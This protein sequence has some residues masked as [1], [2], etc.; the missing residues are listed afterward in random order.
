MKRIIG[1]V[2]ACVCAGALI[3]PAIAPAKA[4]HHPAQLVFIDSDTIGNTIWV[5]AAPGH[6]PQV[7]GQ[8]DGQVQL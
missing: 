6:V 5:L 4:T 3:L 8:P 7:H 2:C 1:G